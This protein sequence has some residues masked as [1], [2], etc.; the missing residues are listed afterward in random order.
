MGQFNTSVWG[1]AGGGGTGAAGVTVAQIIDPM[2]RIAGITTLPGITPNVDQRGELI[3]MLSRMLG[4]WNL[5]GH[6]IYTTKI[7]TFTLNT[8]QKI[9]TIGPGGDFDTDRPLFIKTANCLYPTSPVVRRP[10]AILDDN[11][12][13][14]IGIQDITGAPVWQLYYDG[15][16]DDDGLGNIYL[17]FQPPD[18]YSLELYTWQAIATDFTGVTDVV[19]LPPGYWEALV[20]NGARRVVGLNPLDSKLD[21]AQRTELKQ[22]A[23]QALQAV[24]TLN[25]SCPKIGT[26]AGLGSTDDDSAIGFRGWLDGGYR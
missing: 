6:K 3:P 24:M 25:M 10:V 22:L 17:R 23:D 21:G 16:M 12:W 8:D 2:L 13:A 7:E 20:L 19:V 15:G 18:G 1:G 14:A 4:S 9:Y 11:E 26:E 5:D